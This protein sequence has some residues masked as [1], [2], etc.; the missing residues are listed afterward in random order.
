MSGQMKQTECIRTKRLELKSYRSSDKEQLSK[1]LTNAEVTKT[2]MVPEF[3]SEKQVLDLV[4]KLIV[5]SKAEDMTHLEYGIY[6]KDTLIGFLN[7]CGIEDETIEIGY[8]IHPDL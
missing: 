5:F 8:V 4:N 3:K 6:L 7:D 2:F 1:L